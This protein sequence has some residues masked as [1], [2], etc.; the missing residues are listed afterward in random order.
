[1]TL[2]V[3]SIA[4]LISIVSIIGGGY[5][6]IIRRIDKNKQDQALNDE[7]INGKLNDI[8]TQLRSMAQLVQMQIDSIQ[9]E[10]KEVKQWQKD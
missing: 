6:S 8:Q 9:K 1:M 3:N 7:K 10:I 5:V 2:D 4:I